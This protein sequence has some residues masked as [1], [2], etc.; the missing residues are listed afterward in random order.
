MEPPSSNCRAGR[1]LHDR[2]R[3]MRHGFVKTLGSYISGVPNMMQR[4]PV[5]RPAEPTDLAPARTFR[6]SPRPV[7]VRYNSE[8]SGRS[9]AAS[10]QWEGT[11]RGVT[12][13]NEKAGASVGEFYEARSALGAILAQVRAATDLKDGEAA[14]DAVA[15]VLG[16]PL[17]C[18]VPDTSH[19][20]VL[21][22]AD[23]YARSRGWP[24]ELLEFWQSCHAALKM[25]LYIRCRF[26]TL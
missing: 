8:N 7:E 11:P 5:L 23:A 9:A 2:F 3:T 17:V 15:D 22:E 4:R 16:L 10:G 6:R 18:W 24:Q 12:I 1:K 14:L 20:Y 13:I 19:P 25:P 21:P 26:E